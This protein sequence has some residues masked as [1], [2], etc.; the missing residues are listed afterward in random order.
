MKINKPVYVRLDSTRD[1]NNCAIFKKLKPVVLFTFRNIAI[2]IKPYMVRLCNWNVISNET[3]TFSIL[4]QVKRD[5]FVI[6][7]LIIINWNLLLASI[8]DLASGIRN[9]PRESIHHASTR[10]HSNYKDSV[11][12]LANTQPDS[13]E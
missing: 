11:Q 6:H 7:Q 13:M 1:A 10:H 9:R 4:K 12:I 2:Y 5:G 3:K 8:L